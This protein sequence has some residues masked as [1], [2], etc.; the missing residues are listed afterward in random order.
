MTKETLA[1]RKCDFSDLNHDSP[2]YGWMTPDDD[3]YYTT[4]MEH[5]SFARD[6]SGFFYNDPKGE[7]VLYAHSWLSIHPYGIG[8]NYLFTWKG[9]LTDKQKETVKPFV[10]VYKRWVD[11]F[12]K[13][14][15]LEELEIE[16]EEEERYAPQYLPER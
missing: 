6:L 13:W 14:R 7:D 8:S 12:T 9:H 4:Y 11:D 2:H 15:L 1:E 5:S 10:E 16:D 3:F